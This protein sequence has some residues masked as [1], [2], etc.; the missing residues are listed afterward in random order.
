MKF[1][2]SCMV[3]KPIKGKNMITEIKRGQQ[4]NKNLQGIHLTLIVDGDECKY[5]NS[6]P[7][8]LSDEEFQKFVEARENSYRLDILKDMYP[9][10]KYDVLEGQS[11]LEAFEEWIKDGCMLRN[12]ETGEYTDKVEK[13]PFQGTH[14]KNLDWENRIDGAESLVAL[15]TVLKEIL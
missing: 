8:G 15:K 4:I 1:I 11:E 6:A 7:S 13:V 2:L 3:F 14:P 10:A 5:N 12:P 9:E